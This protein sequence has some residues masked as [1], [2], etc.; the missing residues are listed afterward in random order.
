LLEEKGRGEELRKEVVRL[1]DA[2]TEGHE[3]EDVR[4]A[5]ELLERVTSRTR[6]PEQPAETIRVSS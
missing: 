4:L 5:N 1:C 3:L 2:M 6:S